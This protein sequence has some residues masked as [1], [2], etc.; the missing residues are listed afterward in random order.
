MDAGSD[1][2]TDIA[3]M[4]I[5]CM[6]FVCCNK[7]GVLT[8]WK[9]ANFDASAVLTHQLFLRH[10]KKVYDVLLDLMMIKFYCSET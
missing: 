10:V 5:Q 3:S 9:I 6:S 7:G 4:R 1:A 2:D 8:T